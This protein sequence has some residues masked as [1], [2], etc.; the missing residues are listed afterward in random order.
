[1]PARPVRAALG[2]L[3]LGLLA[4]C[5]GLATLG[6]VTEPIELYEI[7]PK[8]TYDPDMPEIT[9]QL[10]VEE[11][12]AA[13]AVNTDRIAVKP[14]AF[15]VEYFPRARWVDR[16]PLMVQTR[17]VESFEN[18]GKVGSVG[19]QAIGLT[20]D[21]T[22][23]SELREFQAMVRDDRSGPIS[24]L[25][26]LNIKIV[27]Q[28]QGLIVASQSFGAEAEA[29]SDDMTDVVAAFDAALGSTMREAVVWTV[30]QIARFSASGS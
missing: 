27:K 22:L 25:V 29:A 3:A 19:R 1:M 18:T 15:Q 2:A 24:A 14:N 23:V 11:P 7:S 16:A 21:Y 12:T 26:Q 5:T 4:G 6:A 17:L 9:A 28:P 10:V 30:E 13:S 8:S 20:S